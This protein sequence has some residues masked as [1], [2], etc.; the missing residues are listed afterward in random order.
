MPLPTPA[1]SATAFADSVVVITGAA[2]GIGQ[3]TAEAF[4][5]SGAHAVLL[6]HDAAQLATTAQALGAATAV[7]GDVA[8]W[9]GL[10]SGFPGCSGDRPPGAGAGQQRR[11][12]PGQGRRRHTGQ[13]GHQ[14]RCQRQGTALMAASIAPLLQAA[15]GGAIANLAS[16]SGLLRPAPPLDL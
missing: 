10:S 7:Y 6:D 9:A 15:G 12:V 4:V 13:L 11:D 5:S 14:P 16:V 1:Q 8:R 3:A 2:S